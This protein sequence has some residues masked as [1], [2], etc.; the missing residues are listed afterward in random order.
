MRR[1]QHGTII[2]RSDKWYVSYWQ[3]HNVNGTVERKRVTHCLGEKTTRGK[4]PPDAIEAGCKRFMAT[5]N[6]TSQTVKPEH[7][8]TIVDFVDSVYMPWVRANKRAATVNGYEKLWKT[9]LKEHFGNMLLRDYQPRH[10][11]VFLTKLAEK[12]MGLNAVS[13]VRSLMS[14]VFKHA[15]ALGYT[16]TNPIH[17]AKVLVTPRAPK[18]TPHYTIMEMASALTVLQGQTQARLVMVLTFIGLRPS[19][20]RG[21]KLEDV[22]LDGGVLHVRRSAWRSSINE[23]GKGKNSSRDVTLGPVVIGILKEHMEAQRSQRGFLL[24]NTL[25]MPL[26]LNALARDVIKPTFAASG[27]EWKGYYGGRRG[28]ETEMNRYTNGNS[29]ITSHHFGH[30]KAVADAH[31]IKPIPEE[32]KVAALALDSTLRETIGRLAAQAGSNVN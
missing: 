7:V 20:I 26:D 24:E 28:A 21:L 16:S 29:Q 19:E 12:G 31:Y 8:L 6:T 3:E 13:H 18:A 15:A 25:G 32:T 30:T 4:N 14:G 5:V 17:F 11:T 23:G 10:A 1:E 9:H 27:L 22:D 2:L